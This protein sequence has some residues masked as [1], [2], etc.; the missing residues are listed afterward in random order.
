MYYRVLWHN[1]KHDDFN[2]A[3]LMYSKLGIMLS[4]LIDVRK[5]LVD[6]STNIFEIYKFHNDTYYH[7]RI[8][9]NYRNTDTDIRESNIYLNSTLSNRK[10]VVKYLKSYNLI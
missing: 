6:Y 4:I 3:Y 2:G 8:T 10:L 1:R 7:G 5:D 9:K